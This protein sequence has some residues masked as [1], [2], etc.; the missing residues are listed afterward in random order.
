MRPPVRA[1][2]FGGDL[3][4]FLHKYK[5]Q[6]KLT[7]K[8]DDLENLN[9]TPELLNEIVLWKVNRYVSRGSASLHRCPAE[10]EAGRARKT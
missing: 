3:S 6:P 1:T 4:E 8:L 5:F 10:A 7:R 9:L 2:E